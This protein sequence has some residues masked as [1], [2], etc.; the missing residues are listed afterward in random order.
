M[1]QKLF[2]FFLSQE[3]GAFRNYTEKESRKPRQKLQIY[4]YILL[5]YKEYLVYLQSNARGSF[6]VN[7]Y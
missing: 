5:I 3:A 2:L 1:Q 7:V 6:F 4:I